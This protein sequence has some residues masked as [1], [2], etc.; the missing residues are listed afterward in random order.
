MYVNVFILN[1]D[2]FVDFFFEVGFYFIMFLF[3]Q[4][5]VF[6]VYMLKLEFILSCYY[7]FINDRNGY[8]KFCGIVIVLFVGVWLL[9]N[10]YVMFLW[11][12]KEYLS[13]IY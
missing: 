3:V 7:V 6:Y 10:F 13:L 4:L 12:W 2:C 11:F 1:V 9:F 8:I 5:V